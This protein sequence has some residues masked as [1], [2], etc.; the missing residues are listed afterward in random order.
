MITTKPGQ[1]ASAEERL[2]EDRAWLKQAQ[3][4]DVAAFERLVTRYSARVYSLAQRMTG[5]AQ[6][7]QEIVQET[8]LSA[9]QN[10]NKFR[11]DSAFGSWV[12]RIGANLALMRLRHK[13]VV[14]D[15]E[16]QLK[17]AMEFS[18]DGC[19]LTY[20]LTQWSK[21][22]DEQALDNELRVAI[23]KAVAFGRSVTA[24]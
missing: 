21:R 9:Y 13:R 18:E 19:L 2:A 17:G 4:G 1:S 22:A 14:N 10:L 11:G 23:E 5:N 16:E 12:H 15:A 24:A 6:D 8:F 7:A 3:A 20:P